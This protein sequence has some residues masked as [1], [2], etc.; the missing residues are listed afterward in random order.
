MF[1]LEGSEEKAFW[2]SERISPRK[3]DCQ[4]SPLTLFHSNA[5]TVMI[6]SLVL[7][8]LA[9]ESPLRRRGILVCLSSSSFQSSLLNSF[10][11][12]HRLASQGRCPSAAA[13][14][15]F[16]HGGR[17]RQRLV[18]HP[19]ARQ[20]IV[21]N[22]KAYEDVVRHHKTFSPSVAPSTHRSGHRHAEC[23]YSVG[24][25]DGQGLSQTQRRSCSSCTGILTV[26]T[27]FFIWNDVLSVGLEG[28]RLTPGPAH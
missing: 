16:F 25:I 24:G 22:P 15:H 12:C 21:R 17:G 6:L 3:P 1:R 4:R 20:H 19:R 2:F 26:M 8:R 11:S 14:R 18:E 7:V 27:L 5:G 23:L 13:T 28:V 10:F 9:T